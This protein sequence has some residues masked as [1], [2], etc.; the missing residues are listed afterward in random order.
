MVCGT[1]QHLAQ[2]RWIWILGPRQ[3]RIGWTAKDSATKAL[4]VALAKAAKRQQ[5]GGV[6]VALRRSGLP[7]WSGRAFRPLGYPANVLVRESPELVQFYGRHGFVYDF[8]YRSTVM[9]RNDD[10]TGLNQTDGNQNDLVALAALM[11]HESLDTT[12]RYVQRTPE[13][14]EAASERL[15]F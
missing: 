2:H 6:L 1:A 3:T 5:E 14:L 15:G 9:A 4:F 8:R 7:A 10:T 13:Q 12:R 11:G